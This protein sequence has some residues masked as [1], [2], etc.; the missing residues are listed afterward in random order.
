M[1]FIKT[2][3][4][5]LI[6]LVVLIV[7]AGA[8][9]IKTV[10]VNKY[11]GQITQQMSNA[12]QKPVT[13]DRIDFNPSLSGVRLEIVDM[14]I[15]GL[16]RV[17]STYLMVDLMKYITTKT[18]VVPKVIIK[19]PQIRFDTADAPI[20]GGASVTGGSKIE[21]SDQK[22][23]K[24]LLSSD[25]LASDGASSSDG[26][27]AYSS[28]KST[29]QIP[30][31]NIETIRIENGSLEYID[32]KAAKPMQVS[33]RNLDV[34]IKNLSLNKAFPYKLSCALFSADKDTIELSGNAMYNAQSGEVNIAD[35]VINVF[36]GRMSMDEIVKS[37]PD[38]AQ[39]G[40]KEISDGTIQLNLK[41]V[42]LTAAGMPKR[43]SI[44]GQLDD[45]KLVLDA[46]KGPV[47]LDAKFIV[48]D[49]QIQISQADISVANGKIQTKGAIQ[50]YLADMKYQFD[51]QIEG[52]DLPELV[53]QEA[54]PVRMEGKAQGNIS[55]AGNGIDPNVAL[56]NLS[57]GGQVNVV[58]GRLMDINLLKVVLNNIS[59]FPNFAAKLSENLSDKYKSRLEDTN[60][61]LNDVTLAFKLGG[62]RVEIEK[63]QLEADGFVYSA[64][65]NMDFEQNLVLNSAFKFSKDLSDTMLKTE[66]ETKNL[67][68]QNGQINFPFR[69]YQG[70]AEKY[71]PIPDATGLLKQGIQNQIQRGKGELLNLLKKELDIK[72]EPAKVPE[73]GAEEGSAPAE[74]EA[75]EPSTEEVLIESVVDSLPFFK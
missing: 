46:L 73:N 43:V 65:G 55:I 14:N 38:L 48:E 20:G 31:F 37:V 62:G 26:Q 2:L 59:F 21:L 34:E 57:G 69:K 58:D 47:V 39:A 23:S 3:F 19:S 44:D 68:D 6:V 16:A 54:L 74:A 9:F 30:D 45:L 56:A 4:I 64:Q 71:K 12:L 41:D 22:S 5:I 52:I 1:K 60:T 28:Q 40:L 29:G 27:T 50:D 11:K 36:P 61:V 49:S 42:L 33:V 63:V 53:D 15:E 32:S 51:S 70:K 25:P 8:V 67:M 17:N 7:V 72:E 24:G 13:I 75:K 18:V 66:A 35:L 10:D